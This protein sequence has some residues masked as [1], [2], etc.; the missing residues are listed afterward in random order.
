ME[1]PRQIGLLLGALIV[2]GSVLAQPASDLGRQFE[3]L[4]Q[5]AETTG[6]QWFA[7]AGDARQAESLEIAARALDEAAEAGLPPVQIGLERS[8]LHIAA[9]HKDLAV[10]ELQK[11]ADGGFT[12]VVFLTGDPVIN[13]LSGHAGY[14]AIVAAMSVQAYPCEHKEGFSDFD[15]WLGEWEVHVA[16]GAKA[17]SNVIRKAERGCVL[18]E[19][20]TN[21]RGGTGMS[22]NYLDLTTNEWVQIWNAEGGS[23]INVRGGLT[24]DGMRMEGHIHYVGNGT[25]APFRALWTPLPDGRVRQFFEQ[26]NDGGETWTPWFEGFYSRR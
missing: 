17:G 22:V 9:D 25:T 21:V 8:R 11:L 7:L 14:D 10:G 2:A 12:S 19:N 13:S 5:N 3:E 1:Q 16:N 24:K 15:F 23:Q 18:I 4:S 26:S 6:Q 20:W